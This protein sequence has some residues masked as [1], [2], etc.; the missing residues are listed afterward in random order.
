M[1]ITIFY[2]DRHASKAFSIGARV[3][4][5]PTP[6]LYKQ[7]RLYV[8]ELLSNDTHTTDENPTVSSY[9]FYNGEILGRTTKAAQLV[10]EIQLLP[11]GDK[12]HEVVSA[13]VTFDG[14]LYVN[15]DEGRVVRP[16]LSMKWWKTSIRHMDRTI[17]V[18]ELIHTG[19]VRYVDASECGAFDITW[20]PNTTV[21]Q[22]CDFAEIHPNLML[23]ITAACIP[24]LQCTG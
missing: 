17:C 4:Q 8:I 5:H 9:V 14:Q 12:I 19:G 16:L 22:M 15:T 23:G 2:H 10:T 3:T 1:G 20:T 13:V 18:D 6:E 11:I 21:G 24:F 7:H